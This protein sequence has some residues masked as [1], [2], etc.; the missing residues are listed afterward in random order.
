MK[1]ELNEVK[2]RTM[3]TRLREVLGR[4]ALSHGRA[5][6]AL[7]A[8]LG[9][10]TW[11]LLSG[12]LK[13]EVRPAVLVTA[14]VP[15]YLEAFSTGAEGYGPAW[16]MLTLDQT[17]LD[18]MQALQAFCKEQSL[19]H[20]AFD[21][22][23]DLWQGDQ[24]EEGGAEEEDCGPFDMDPARL[25]VTAEGFWLR[26]LPCRGSGATETRL[27]RFLDLIEGLSGKNSARL[28]AYNGVLA[29][30]VTCAPDVF[31]RQ[32]VEEKALSAEH[33]PA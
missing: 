20:V 12:L 22:E 17:L 16:A 4:D 14:A 3:A 26:A 15:L 27:L 30:S 25:Y 7:S 2:I 10:K 5:L 21:L 31:V 32:L 8:V 18:R 28:G 24:L 29:W 13:R 33:R 1:V 11:D 23:P 19:S 9:Y 6:E